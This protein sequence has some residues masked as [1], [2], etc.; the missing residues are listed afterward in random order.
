MYYTTHHIS[1][2]QVAEVRI[3]GILISMLHKKGKASLNEHSM[4]AKHKCQ[5][6]RYLAWKKSI[7]QI[8]AKN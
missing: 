5:N 2:L 6:C 3:R 7:K 4:H 8:T 1:F